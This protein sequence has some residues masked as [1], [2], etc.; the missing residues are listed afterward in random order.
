MTSLEQAQELENAI[1]SGN[2]ENAML[3]AQV[4]A[5]VKAP[6]IIKSALIKGTNGG[7]ADKASQTSVFT[8]R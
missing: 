2:V 4:L 5:L 3:M 8:V 6:I 7:S 1:R